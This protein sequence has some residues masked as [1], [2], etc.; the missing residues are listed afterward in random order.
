MKYKGGALCARMLAG[1]LVISML[2]SGS[3]ESA[4]ES[5]ERQTNLAKT[6]Q[7]KANYL[8]D[9]SESFS[10]QY[11]LIDNGEITISGNV[12]KMPEKLTKD[13]V[14]GIGS[15]SK[16]FAA[17]AVM[18]LVDEGKINLD[19]PVYQYIP[20]FHMKDERYKQISPRMLLNHSSGLRGTESTND[21]LLGDNDTYVHDK[22]LETLAEQT[23]KADPG[24]FSVYCNGGFS[25]TEI[26]VERVSGM[27]FTDFLHENFMKPLKME[28]SGMPQDPIDASKF[29]GYYMED[30]S[31][32]SMVDYCNAIASG[33]VESTAEDMVRFA[34]V[35][36]GEYTDVLS[37]DSV[38]AMAEEEYKRGM[39]PGDVDDCN[40]Y[41][42]GWD[43]VKLYPFTEYGIQ[44]LAKGGDLST[45]HA[46]FVV[47]PEEK[48]AVAVLTSGGNSMANQSLACKMLLLALQDKGRISMEKEAKTFGKPVLAEM[49]AELL[50]YVGTYAASENQFEV[51]MTKKGELTLTSDSDTTYLYTGDGNFVNSDGNSQMCFVQEENGR[52][53]LWKRSYDTDVEFVQVADSQYIAEK[54]E[55][56]VIS[57]HVAKTWKARE[58]KSYYILNQKYSSDAYVLDYP[59]VEIEGLDGK[60]GY[61]ADRKI[62]DADTAVS[63]IQIPGQEGR[64]TIEARFYHKN[65]AEYLQ[66][67]ELLCI[68]EEAVTPLNIKTQDKVQITTDGYAR[69]YTIPEEAFNKTLTVTIPK[70]AA[71]VVYDANGKCINDSYLSGK[72]VTTLPE[73][74]TIAFVGNAGSEFKLVLKE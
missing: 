47:L 71:Y 23:L 57:E 12:G 24:A 13:T 30:G 7:E 37:Q 21:A 27:S 41:G 25:L 34:E 38:N 59:T 16:V 39:W 22:L 33:G 70:K 18:K 62:L 44:A 51:K 43:S 52:T 60:T 8:M 63:E 1:V 53:Y 72:N 3:G 73:G 36:M 26:L 9:S 66:Q 15:V 68:S 65:G 17:A 5:S 55:D 31:K 54:L 2:L 6:I 20:E 74:G 32:L 58:G 29:A 4:K 35:F 67:S 42:L 48:M 46:S 10:V 56:N 19:T 14:Y 11:A 50:Q 61:W 40:N 28:H 45:Y 69:W 49:P 64:D